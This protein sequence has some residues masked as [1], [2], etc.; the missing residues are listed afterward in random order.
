MRGQQNVGD[1]G[2]VA[3]ARANDKRHRDEQ[4]KDLKDLLAL[5]AFRRLIWRLL[6]RARVFESIDAADEHRRS[7]N[8]GVQ[9]F[10]HFLM[11]EII[12]ADEEGFLKMQKE[13][14]MEDRKD[15]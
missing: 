9:D 8:I 14:F 11:A 6:G 5:P 12:E 15:D 13:Q 10:G 2:S 4:I 1:A 3:V 7:Y